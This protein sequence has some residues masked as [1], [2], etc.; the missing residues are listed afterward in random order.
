[1]LPRCSLHPSQVL[2]TATASLVLQ[3]NSCSVSPQV[4]SGKQLCQFKMWPTS[5]CLSSLCRS[6]TVSPEYERLYKKKNKKNQCLN[7]SEK[8]RWVNSHHSYQHLLTCCLCTKTHD[9]CPGDLFW[10]LS[11]TRKKVIFSLWL[12]WTSSSATKPFL[13]WHVTEASENSHY[14]TD[15][16]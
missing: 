10:H 15:S 13:Q 4:L 11:C 14:F 16:W 5:R 12:G 6:C 8:V 7:S 3:N 2:Y 1:M 9:E